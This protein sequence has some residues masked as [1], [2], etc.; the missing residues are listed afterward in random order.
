MWK[1]SSEKLD[2]AQ[3][4]SATARIC[5]TGV[6]VYILFGYIDLYSLNPML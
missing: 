4:A 3:A 1:V 5:K 2:A 6:K